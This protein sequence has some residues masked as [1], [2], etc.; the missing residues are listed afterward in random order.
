MHRDRI[1]LAPPERRELKRRSGS[2]TIR[3]EDARR[4]QLIVLL[5]SG[6]TRVSIQERLACTPAFVNKW[7]KRFREGRVP[8]LTSRKAPGNPATV[9]TPEM[10]ARILAVIRTP[11]RW[12]DALEHATVGEAPGRRSHGRAPGVAAC[13]PPAAPAGVIPGVERPGLREE[14]GGRDRAVPESP[15]K[16]RRLQRGREDGSPAAG[17]H[18][19]GA[20]HVS[21][22]RGAPRLR[23]LPPR[24]PL[25]DRRPR[26]P[27]GEVPGKTLPGSAASPSLPSP[28]RSSR[29]SR[30]A[31]RSTSSPTTSPLTRLGG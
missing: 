25:V 13:E 17:P 4:A 27:T 22:P 14:G 20:P 11:P 6:E 7:S 26:H 12:L 10:E 31:G 1:I 21:R 15:G 8:A 18:R 5:A 29:V 16:R 9:L 2:R 19:A 23:V 24:R 3:Q 30:G 28:R